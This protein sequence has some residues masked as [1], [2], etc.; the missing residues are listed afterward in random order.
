[1]K[2]RR[3]P[4]HVQEEELPSPFFCSLNTCVALHLSV[5]LAS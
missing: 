2:W 4:W 1:M 5:W 3:L